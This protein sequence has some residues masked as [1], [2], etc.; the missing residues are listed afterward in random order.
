MNPLLIPLTHP[1]VSFQ[2]TDE[3]VTR[4]QRAR[5]TLRTRHRNHTEYSMQSDKACK[6]NGEVFPSRRLQAHRDEHRTSVNPP[7]PRYTFSMYPSAQLCTPYLWAHVRVCSY[8]GSLHSIF[9]DIERHT[10]E[11]GVPASGVNL[12]KTFH[13]GNVVAL[14]CL[15]PLSTES[16]EASAGVLVTGGVYQ[17]IF[18]KC[19]HYR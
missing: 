5:T 16:G 7:S 2:K 9:M 8:S 15:R 14:A 4:A 10:S 13:T 18:F 11:P 12:L 1:Q 19:S 17:K 6:K 3:S